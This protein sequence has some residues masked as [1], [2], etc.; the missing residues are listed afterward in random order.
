MKKL[1]PRRFRYRTRSGEFFWPEVSP[2]LPRRV[3]YGAF[4]F[5]L[6]YCAHLAAF[7]RSEPELD[8]TSPAAAALAAQV[9]PIDSGLC[10]PVLLALVK[11]GI[12]PVAPT[13]S[14]SSTTSSRS[15]T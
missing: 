11:G 3:L 14:S 6:A 7:W 2:T 15:G 8:A 13:T 9:A 5:Y 10:E 4:F 12:A 1:R